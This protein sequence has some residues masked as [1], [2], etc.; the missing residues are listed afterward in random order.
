M[1]FGDYK[2]LGEAMSAFQV[3]AT[4]AEFVNPRPFSISDYFRAALQA[5]LKKIPVSCSEWA[6]CENLLYPVLWEVAKEY[7]DELVIWSH[8]TLYQGSDLLGVPDY[9][10]AKRSPLGTEVLGPPIAMIMEAKRNDFD[11]GWGQCLA[12]M[13]A[14]QTLNGDSERIIYGGVSDGFVW[15]FGKLQGKTLS[16]HPQPYDIS[17]LDE[18]LGALNHVLDLCKQQ[19]LSPAHAA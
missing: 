18:L 15:R 1:A 8:I 6:V 7:A 2:T 11:W 13:C 19:V 4:V 3:T 14:A 12:A 5:R 10:I 17:R 9:L 16:R